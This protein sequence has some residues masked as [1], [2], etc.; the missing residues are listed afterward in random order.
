MTVKDLKKAI[1]K[2]PDD[3]IVKVWNTITDDSYIDAEEIIIDPD[4]TR[5]NIVISD[6]AGD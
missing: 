3:T 1:D 5:P 4:D 2:L 6:I